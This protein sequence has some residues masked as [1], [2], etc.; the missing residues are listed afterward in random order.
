MAEGKIRGS[1][2]QKLIIAVKNQYLFKQLSTAQKG[3]AVVEHV[4]LGKM[5]D[6]S[7]LGMLQDC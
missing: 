2:E 5:T 4:L 1:G 7:H 3:D 6:S